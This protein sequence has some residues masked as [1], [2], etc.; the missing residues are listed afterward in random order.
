[1]Q[2]LLGARLLQLW[3]QVQIRARQGRTRLCP[4]ESAFQEEEVQRL[5]EKGVLP[6]RNKVPV[7]SCQG[8]MGQFGPPQR[9]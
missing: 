5:L 3:I 6:L 2:N 1:M 8:S 7:R 4:S 9:A